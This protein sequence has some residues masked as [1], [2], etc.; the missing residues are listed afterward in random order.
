MG[1]TRNAFT[2]LCG[3]LMVVALL[4]ATS[5]AAADVVTDW[6]ALSV[7]F[8]NTAARPAPTFMLDI[9][10]VHVAIHDAVQAYQHRF[11]AYDTPIANAA[12][13]PVALFLPERTA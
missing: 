9:A 10:M 12:G 5:P 8:I 13:S 1:T 4:G 3:S 2:R 11:R 6:N 7:G